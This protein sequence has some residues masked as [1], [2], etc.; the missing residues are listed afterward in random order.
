MASV[1][2]TDLY[3]ELDALGKEKLGKLLTAAPPPEAAEACVL[4]RRRRRESGS[5]CRAHAHTYKLIV[6]FL[7]AR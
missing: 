4:A 1:D 6:S 7:S 2:A 5:L 3:A